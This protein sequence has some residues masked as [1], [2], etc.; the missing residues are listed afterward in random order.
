MDNV[1]SEE[2]LQPLNPSDK[3]DASEIN[4]QSS[5]S[6]FLYKFKSP[7]ELFDFLEMSKNNQSILKSLSK[8]SRNILNSLK[9]FHSVK[10]FADVWPHEAGDETYDMY[11]K[12]AAGDEKDRSLKK[13]YELYKSNTD[14]SLNKKSFLEKTNS[15]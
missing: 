1:I 10:K 11:Q 4:R 14:M 3:R 6:T 7:Q 13:L 2:F 15:D 5:N 8:I 9:V 12:K